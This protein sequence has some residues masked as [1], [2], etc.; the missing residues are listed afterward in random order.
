MTEAVD[1]TPHLEERSIQVTM[2]IDPPDECP[3][4]NVET[5]I[6]KVL[7]GREGD[8]CRCDLVLTVQLDDQVGT[9]VAQIAGDIDRCA[10]T[11]FEEYG[12]V[13]QVIGVDQDVVTVRVFLDDKVD[14][15]G[16]LRSLNEVCHGVKITEMTTNFDER[17]GQ[18]IKEIDLSSFT[19]LQKE[20]IELAI[21]RGYYRRPREVTLEELA[22]E[23]DISQQA[24]AQRL[25]R[26]EQ[27]IM[28]Q[29]V[30]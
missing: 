10:G 4:T 3:L 7:V 20:T 29:L 19:T 13:P 18:T 5:E 25:A 28:E 6:S 15:D 2:E 16:L 21:E 8:T 9:L 12:C 23:F 17:M 1:D 11:V 26:A 14:I 30:P 22:G 27:K 24:L